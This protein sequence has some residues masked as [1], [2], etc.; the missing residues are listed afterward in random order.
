MFP[1]ELSQVLADDYRYISEVGRG[2]MAI[3][4]RARDLK[5]DRDVAIKLLRPE[6]ATALGIERFLREIRIASELEHPHIVPLFNSGAT[7]RA[8]YYV[9]PFIA[10]STVRQVLRAEGPLAVGKAVRLAS[11][12]AKAL[13]YAH[14]RGIVH[15][16]I[17]PEN[18]LV[19]DGHAIVADFGLARAIDLAGGPMLTS[20]GLVVGTVEYMSPEQGST[21][22]VDARSD[23]YSMGCLVYE[24]LGGE[25][26]FTGPSIQA[27]VARH[28]HEAPRSLRVIRPAITE[29]MERAV[30]VAL[31]KVPADRYQTVTEFADALVSA[32]S[33]AGTP[34]V[35]VSRPEP[36]PKRLMSFIHRQPLLAMVS[37]IVVL[38]AGAGTALVTSPTIRQKFTGGATAAI[39]DPVSASKL[40]VL[41][42]EV[43]DTGQQAA[44]LGHLMQ[45]LLVSELGRQ[46]WLA[47][48]D[49]MSL[50]GRVQDT[51]RGGDPMAALRDQGLRYVLSSSMTVRGTTTDVTWVLSDARDGQVMKT[52][53]FSSGEA[54]LAA[55]VRTAATS[56]I[57]AL[58]PVAGSGPKGRDLQPFLSRPASPEAVNAFLQGTEY[59]YR[60]I[61]G[62][63]RFFERAV[64]LDPDFVAPRVWLV[65]GLAGRGDTAAAREHV[66][67][68]QQLRSRATP[69]EQAMIDWADAAVR[70]DVDAKIRHVRVALGYSPG[71]NGLLFTLGST[72]SIAG[73]REE[74]LAVLREA[75]ESRWRF[76]PLYELWGTLSIEVGQ[77]AGLRTTL[78][79]AGQSLTPST[80]VLSALVEALSLH[81]GDLPTAS[82]FHASFEASLDSAGRVRALASLLPVYQAFARQPGGEG[83]PRGRATLLQRLREAQAAVA[84]SPASST[85]YKE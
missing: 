19:S 46:R 43:R 56:L 12:T 53:S 21:G 85:S 41:L 36:I 67:I 10:G 70:G 75:V 60:Y 50:N 68:M 11:D 51:S 44:S 42:P 24:M 18:I 26:P 9:M 45:Y 14:A 3:V 16:D 23:I 1:S 79:T 82:R 52:G 66:R 39:P 25:P 5:H 77:L 32:A 57:E 22:I 62:G 31:E 38:A 72:L 59:S 83:D 29:Q 48:L 47:V 81:D 49:P 63:G 37:A 76:A 28:M 35:R 7:D 61:P 69:F 58:E 55:H 78:E 6:L 30:L 40:A 80:P 27:I 71:N 33:A 64:E 34:M 20:S 73:R 2:G 65:S 13:A 15:R 54:D 17:K 84:P 74:A 4:Y 8:P